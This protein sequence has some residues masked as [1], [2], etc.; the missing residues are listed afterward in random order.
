MDVEMRHLLVPVGA[1]IGE[2]TIA[3]RDQPV[4]ARHGAD[5][6]HEAGDLVCTRRRRKIVPR[7]TVLCI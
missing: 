4:V 3:R 5:G 7:I 2:E 6:A 1:D